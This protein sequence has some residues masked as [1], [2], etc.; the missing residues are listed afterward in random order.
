MEVSLFKISTLD[1]SRLWRER[2]K[3]TVLIVE[4]NREDAA[5]IERAAL[6]EGFEVVWERSAEGAL[7]VLHKNGKD[8][9]SVFVDVGLPYMDGWTLAL[10][11]HKHWPTL[12][13]CI[14]SGAH[15]RLC[16]TEKGRMFNVLWKSDSYYDVFRQLKS[17]KNL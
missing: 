6:A 10:E 1:L 7:G 2:R 9:V 17:W 5:L 13:V 11:I 8:Y 15:E 12:T 4:D 14:M 16:P 3:P